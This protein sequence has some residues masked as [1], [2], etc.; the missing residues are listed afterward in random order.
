MGKKPLPPSQN[1]FQY[2]MNQGMNPG[3]NMGMNM[4]MNQGPPGQWSQWSQG[5]NP[6][7]YM[8]QQPVQEDLYL[9]QGLTKALFGQFK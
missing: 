9:G 8:N 3:M 2:P 6:G 5:P 7:Q 4:G 1:Q